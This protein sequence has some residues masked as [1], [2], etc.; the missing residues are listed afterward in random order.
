MP[1][2]TKQK[3][4]VVVEIDENKYR[5]FSENAKE[6]I[7]KTCSIYGT[8]V[9]NKA[10]DLAKSDYLD[11]SEMEVNPRN[12]VDASTM[13]RHIKKR[14]LSH[15]VLEV[16]SQLLILASGIMVDFDEFR[17]S[18]LYVVIFVIVLFTTAVFVI[19]HYSLESAR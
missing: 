16:I 7:I 3:M 10:F 9:A 13:L 4:E 14:K 8:D 18:S 11:E 17:N 5:K 2:E 6:K 15:I 1:I 19:I 12:I